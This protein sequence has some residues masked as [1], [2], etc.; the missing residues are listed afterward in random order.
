M[1]LNFLFQRTCSMLLS[2]L[3]KCLQFRSLNS[4]LK[5]SGNSGCMNISVTKCMQYLYLNISLIH[6]YTYTYTLTLTEYRVTFAKTE[7]RAFTRRRNRKRIR[8]GKSGSEPLRCHCPPSCSW[9][10]CSSEMCECKVCD[11]EEVSTE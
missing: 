7:K 1:L 11:W 8:A 9:R 10:G 2:G 4:K 3:Q 5:V 6:T